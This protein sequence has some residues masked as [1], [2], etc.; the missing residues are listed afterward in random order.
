VDLPADAH[1]DG[2]V[3]EVLVG[4]LKLRGLELHLRLT[5]PGKRRHVKRLPGDDGREH[6]RIVMLMVDHARQRSVREGSPS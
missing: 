1:D 3:I 6:L 5:L 2:V 4:H